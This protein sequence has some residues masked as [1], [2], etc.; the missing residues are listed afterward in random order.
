MRN[1]FKTPGWQPVVRDNLRVLVTGATGGL[2][3]AL[4]AMLTGGSECLV[5]AHGA[6]QTFDAQSPNIIPITYRIEIKIIIY[7]LFCLSEV[8]KTNFFFT[9]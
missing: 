8:K 2:G 5:G 1:V 4:V 9:H 7:P 6:T 3:S